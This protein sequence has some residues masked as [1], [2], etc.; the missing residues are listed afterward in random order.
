MLQ[1]KRWEITIRNVRS[2]NFKK[3]WYSPEDFWYVKCIRITYRAI[4]PPIIGVSF[5]NHN[6]PSALA[7]PISCQWSRHYTRVEIAL[8]C[9]SHLQASCT[10]KLR[11]YLF[12]EVGL[13][14]KRH[15]QF[16]T[17]YITSERTARPNFPSKYH[18]YSLLAARF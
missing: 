12:Q 15:W 4:R 6:W 8:P 18:I 13:Y 10:T 11:V 17:P 7:P 9:A 14:V 3:F 2:T 16:C 5:Q 1:Q